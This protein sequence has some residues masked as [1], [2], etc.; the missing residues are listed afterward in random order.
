MCTDKVIRPAKIRDIQKVQTPQNKDDLHVNI[1]WMLT[2]L[3]PYILKF[4]NKT[5]TVRGLLK[6]NAPWMWDTDHALRTGNGHLL[7][8]HV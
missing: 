7:S 8:M 3:S 2:N 5:H 1:M 6:S 4:A